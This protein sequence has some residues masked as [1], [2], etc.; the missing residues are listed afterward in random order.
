MPLTLKP[1]PYNDLPVEKQKE[2]YEA[3]KA[4]KL[5]GNGAAI[6]KLEAI[7]QI[8][9]L[10]TA[11]YEKAM[12]EISYLNHTPIKV[13]AK[14]EACEK[15][16][17]T[18]IKAV[19][20]TP[21]TTKLA[22]N[23]ILAAPPPTLGLPSPPCSVCGRRP[24]QKRIVIGIEGQLRV[25]SLCDADFAN[26]L[27]CAI[28]GGVTAY[29]KESQRATCD[30]R[31]CRTTACNDFLEAKRPYEKEI[32]RLGIET[33]VSLCAEAADF[34]IL[35]DM[36]LAYTDVTTQANNQAAR[37]AKWFSRYISM[38]TLGE[39]RHVPPGSKRNEHLPRVSSALLAWLPPTKH[40][41]GTWTAL[42][43]AITLCGGE[44]PLAIA[45]YHI[46]GRVNMGASI[47]GKKWQT[48]VWANLQWL[49]G[50]TSD[51]TFVD[52]CF[53]LE[54]NGANMFN[55][56]YNIASPAPLD[57]LLQLNQ[58]GNLVELFNYCSLRIKLLARVL[59]YKPKFN[60]KE[61]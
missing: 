59:P 49:A 60:G 18:K 8:T 13:Q 29:S 31:S 33:R 27:I 20:L 52:T 30:K 25:L 55:K 46:F 16:Q 3:L 56:I 34:Y 10:P 57:V 48:I 58:D 26:R 9:G 23:N 44:L 21:K 36:A 54:H 51:T 14:E 41:E 50:L 40:R 28:C 12:Q 6:A 17:P 45:L 35:N 53:G 32:N 43:D 24:S 38:I 2:I 5:A 11:I 42:D 15:K 22:L 61:K 1:T 19:A 7:Y 37:L 39:A 47:G 4:E